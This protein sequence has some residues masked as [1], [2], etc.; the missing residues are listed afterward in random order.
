[1][2]VGG[3]TVYKCAW[4]SDI[5]NDVYWPGSWFCGFFVKSIS[6]GIKN[7][8]LKCCQESSKVSRGATVDY[9]LCYGRSDARFRGY[10]DAN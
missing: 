3:C 9:I 1:M 10:I 8:I 5:C 2:M 4:L 6:V 7:L